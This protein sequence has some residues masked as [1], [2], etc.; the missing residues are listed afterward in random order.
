M[1]APITLVLL[2]PSIV[3]TTKEINYDLQ[4]KY[5][6]LKHVHMHKAPY[7]LEV[8]CSGTPCQAA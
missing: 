1:N 2:S 6:K 7:R 5:Q 3:F 4:T 8:V